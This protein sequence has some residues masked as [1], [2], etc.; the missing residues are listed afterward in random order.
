MS[1][2]QE[3]MIVKL[4]PHRLCTVNGTP[5]VNHNKKFSKLPFLKEVVSLATVHISQ[6]SLET[7]IT[8]EEM[9]QKFIGLFLVYVA[10]HMS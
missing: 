1:P 7:W 9:W 8:K 2:I 3:F 10:F 4:Q 6:A 5:S